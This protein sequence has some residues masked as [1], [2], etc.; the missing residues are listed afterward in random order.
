M[1]RLTSSFLLGLLLT[2]AITTATVVSASA[3]NTDDWYEYNGSSAVH[4]FSLRFPTNW[5]IKIYSDDL[6]GLLPISANTESYF[7]IRE[8]EGKSYAQAIAGTVSNVVELAEEEDFIL[9]TIDGDIPAKK[10]TYKNIELDETFSKTFV[11]R[12]GLIIALTNTVEEN[13]DQTIQP[14]Q[15]H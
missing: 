4:T 11:K 9:T 3:L 1:K 5:K 14:L 6:Q 8:H 7:L 12:G 10:V 15:T 13:P 2:A